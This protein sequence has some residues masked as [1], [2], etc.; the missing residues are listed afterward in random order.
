MTSIKENRIFIACF[1]ISALM[2][3]VSYSSQYLWKLQPCKLCILQRFP[4][5]AIAA[6]SIL[7]CI[8]NRKK[9]SFHLLQ[10]LFLSSFLL[11]SYHTGIIYGFISDPCQVP[12][13]ISNMDEY[14]RLLKNHVPCSKSG[15]D[16]FNIPA[17]LWNAVLFLIFG[18]L[19]FCDKNGLRN[20]SN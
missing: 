2:L 5:F 12:L 10:F 18:L 19:T 13:N 17:A 15:L 4:L 3:S 16:I 20:L 1:S 9:W 14:F 11:S 7:S 8:I 6:I